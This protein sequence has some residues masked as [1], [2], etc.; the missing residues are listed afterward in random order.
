MKT[1]LLTKKY[2]ERE[3]IKNKRTLD[4]LSEEVGLSART[5]SKYLKKF[6]V[7][8]QNGRKTTQ[9]GYVKIFSPDHPNRD[10]N[11]YVY[12]HRLVMEKKLERHLTKKEV[13]HHIDGDK[14]NNKIQNLELFESAQKHKAFHK[15]I[16]KENDGWAIGFSKCIDCGTTETKHRG[17]GLCRKCFA[18]L[19]YNK[20]KAKKSAD[21]ILMIRHIKEWNAIYKK[22]LN[23]FVL[24]ANHGVT[25]KTWE[26]YTDEE[27]SKYHSLT[28]KEIDALAV[29]DENGDKNQ[30]EN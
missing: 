13:V 5:L 6:G 22:Q 25:G 8:K 17:R 7:R 1:E 19:E 2:F 26:E 20:M 30:N 24:N 12:E 11:K 21:K 27:K 15:K 10:A 4:D 3:Y 23:N 14:L 18:K 29:T 16:D 9:E 28:D